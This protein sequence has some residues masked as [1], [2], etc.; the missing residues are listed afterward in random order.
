VVGG[1]Y[2]DPATADQATEFIEKEF[3]MAKKHR[4]GNREAKKPKKIKP[5]ESDVTSI[6]QML[7][8]GS[9]KKA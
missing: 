7:K 9:G 5:Q 8:S 1:P 2:V 3:D 6:A 4:T